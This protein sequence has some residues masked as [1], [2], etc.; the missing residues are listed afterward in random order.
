MTQPTLNVQQMQ[1]CL[2]ACL[3][4]LRA[5]EVCAE[6]CLDEPQL[7]MLRTCVQL[8]RDCADTCAFTARLLMR[9][10]LLHPTACAM[11]A[12]A[13]AACAAECEKHAAHH[14]H[15]RLCAEACRRCEALCRAL[16]A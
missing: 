9:A 15:C 2:E 5:C 12:E 4:C 11:C 3:A 10:S 8:D 16:A 14:D 1:E 13:G 6:A 7:D